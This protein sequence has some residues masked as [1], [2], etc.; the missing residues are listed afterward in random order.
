M[1]PR[2]DDLFFCELSFRLGTSEDKRAA[3]EPI[4]SRG[5]S[6]SNAPPARYGETVMV[7]R[8]DN[9]M[10]LAASVTDSRTERVPAVM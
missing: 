3:P 2:K 5:R 9:P 8:D 7:I 10:A 6:P 4:G 1:F